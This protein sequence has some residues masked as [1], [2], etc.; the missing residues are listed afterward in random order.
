M[1]T[2]PGSGENR[3]RGQKAASLSRESALPACGKRNY[4]AGA[5]IGKKV[6]AFLSSGTRVSQCPS[7]EEKPT[8]GLVGLCSSPGLRQEVTTETLK[9]TVVFFYN[10][11]EKKKSTASSI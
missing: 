1:Q 5:S 8:V 9:G 3:N 2:S 10:S 7:L 6:V 4:R 11:K